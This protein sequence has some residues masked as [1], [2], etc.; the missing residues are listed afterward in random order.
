MDKVFA[1]KFLTGELHA[2][3]QLCATA[4]DRSDL[5]SE[6]VIVHRLSDDGASYRV[7]LRADM[8]SRRKGEVSGTVHSFGIANFEIME[9]REEFTLA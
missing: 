5:P 2:F 3:A 6:P 1:Y 8:R 7:E 4:R 9:E